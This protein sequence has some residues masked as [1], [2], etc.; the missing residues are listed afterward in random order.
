MPMASRRHFLTGGAMAAVGAVASGVSSR[1]VEAQA[2]RPTNE[3]GC[4]S[5]HPNEALALAIVRA[6]SEPNY[7]SRLL[8]FSETEHGN[9]ANPNHTNSSAALAEVGVYIGEPVILTEKQYPE[10]LN[11]VKGGPIPKALFVL[12]ET[13]GGTFNIA[14]AQTAMS[15]VCRG[16]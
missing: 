2:A 13:L 11:F 12:P 15:M 3:L 16:M 14:T 7:K 4:V 1:A 6:W 10:Y 9:F 8:S 5:Y